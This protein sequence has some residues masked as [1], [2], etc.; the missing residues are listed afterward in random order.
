MD[1]QQAIE[2]MLKGKKVT[3]RY[4]DPNE[5]VRMTDG[6]TV[7]TEDGVSYSAALF[8]SIREYDKSSIENWGKDWSLFKED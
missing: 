1:K 7:E 6:H 3:H 4:F 8:W 5:W 2:A